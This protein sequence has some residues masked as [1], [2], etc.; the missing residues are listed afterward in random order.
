MGFCSISLPTALT[1]W[2]KAFPALFSFP[3]S[4]ISHPFLN[5]VNANWLQKIQNLTISPSL[6]LKIF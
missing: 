6:S 5:S 2:P 1:F 3:D 4:L